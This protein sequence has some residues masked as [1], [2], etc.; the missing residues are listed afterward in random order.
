MPHPQPVNECLKLAALCQ[1]LKEDAKA[2]EAAH[3]DAAKGHGSNFVD[4]AKAAVGHTKDAAGDK[5][6]SKQHEGYAAVRFSS[7]RTAKR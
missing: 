1:D 7:S 2:D 3:K 6:H 5:L 4:E